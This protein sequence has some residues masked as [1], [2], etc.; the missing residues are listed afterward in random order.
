MANMS[1]LDFRV[2]WLDATSVKTPELSRTWAR[3]EVWAGDQCVTQVEATD[4]TLRR[5]VYGSLYPLAEWIATN[6][7]VLTCNMR[8]TTVDTEYWTWRNAR[9]YPWLENHNFRAA[10]DGMAWPD[11]TIASDGA[12]S[13]IV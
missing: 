3:Y 5:S 8:P 10:G 4:S 11:L 13:Q 9:S 7:W 2:E 1:Q 6:W 12:A